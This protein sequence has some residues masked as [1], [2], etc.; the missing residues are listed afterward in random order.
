MKLEI[1]GAAYEDVKSLLQELDISRST[2]SRWRR[3]GKIPQGHRFRNGKV[4]FTEMEAQQI[5]QFANRIEPI[6]EAGR[7]QLALF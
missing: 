7:D 2:L 3:E 4:V 1:G 5:R 6:N